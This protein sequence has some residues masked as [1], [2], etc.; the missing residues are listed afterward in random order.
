MHYVYLLESDAV[1]GQRYVGVT[2]DLKRRLLDHNAGRS[3][4]TSKFCPWRLVTYL[5]FSDRRKAEAFERYIKSGSGHAFAN[6]R[7]WWKRRA[8]FPARSPEA[9]PAE[10]IDRRLYDRSTFSTIDRPTGVSCLEKG[11]PG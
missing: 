2:A 1:P 6:R 7:L 4:H 3:R 10:K 11:R 5:A 8:V 9:S